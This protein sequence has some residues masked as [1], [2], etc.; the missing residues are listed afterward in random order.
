MFD[1]RQE[2]GD[3]RICSVTTDFNSKSK[4]YYSGAVVTICDC[5]FI[6]GCLLQDLSKYLLGSRLSLQLPNC[7]RNQILH[8]TR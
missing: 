1:H 3:G 7:V 6:F 8:C 2:I 5:C 4:S